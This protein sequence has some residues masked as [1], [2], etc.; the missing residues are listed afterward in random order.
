M[1]DLI[2]RSRRLPLYIQLAESLERRIISG[3]LMPGDAL[4]PENTLAREL[5][6]SPVTV[7]NGLRILV[8]KGLI[9]RISGRGTFVL[10]I[11]ERPLAAKAA[12]GQAV[13]KGTYAVAVCPSLGESTW[14]GTVIR[15]L[16]NTFRASDSRLHFLLHPEGDAV[17][18]RD[19]LSDVEGL[20][21]IACPED[22]IGPAIAQAEERS[23]PL[24][25]ILDSDGTFD[26]DCVVCDHARAGS[27]AAKHLAACGYTRFVNLSSGPERRRRV[28][29]KGFARE[30]KRR[31]V[32]RS[33]IS[34]IVVSDGESASEFGRRAAGETPLAEGGVGVLAG[35]DETAAAFTAGA[36]DGGFRA[37]IDYGLLGC[38]DLPQFRHFGITTLSFPYEEVG[39]IA[40]RRLMGLLNETEGTFRFSLWPIL[41]DRGSTRVQD[42]RRAPGRAAK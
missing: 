41:I 17:V 7:K 34:E 16:E 30:L 15:G 36:T 13:R 37:G 12:T 11:E 22:D 2:D 25:T 1:D 4:P 5:G 31:G 23:I 33:N 32:G 38:G 3:K 40:A 19:D 29:S 6:V 27:E 39:R 20:A 42:D 21:M 14:V 10:S 9:K 28:M 24:V 26:A 8:D 18:S 35:S